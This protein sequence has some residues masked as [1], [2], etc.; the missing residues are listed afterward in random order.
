CTQNSP[1]IAPGILVWIFEN[2]GYLLIGNALAAVRLAFGRRDGGSIVAGKSI[3]TMLTCVIFT[4]APPV[5]ELRQ[6]S[7][8]GVQKP[9]HR[10]RRARHGARQVHAT[11]PGSRCSRAWEIHASAREMRFRR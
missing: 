9:R 2:S 8:V 5:P 10:S 11:I 6:T 4:A 7:R 1:G 3:A